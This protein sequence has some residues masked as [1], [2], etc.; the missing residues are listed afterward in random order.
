MTVTD[1]NGC[2]YVN[3]GTVTNN[4]GNFAQ[5]YG[6]AVDEVCSNGAGSIDIVFSG[7]QQPYTFTWSNGAITEDLTGLSAGT[8]TCT[9]VDAGGCTVTTPSYVINNNAGGLTFDNVDVD[10]ETC[11]NGQGKLP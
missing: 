9:V 11:G 5:T 2:K 6:N 7:G 3:N 8:Y 10:D 4:A 1:G